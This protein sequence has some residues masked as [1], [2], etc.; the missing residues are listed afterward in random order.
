MDNAMAISYATG[1]PPRGKAKIITF[2]LTGE[3]MVNYR[4]I[5]PDR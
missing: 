3:Y 1:T 2:G 4:L 5:R